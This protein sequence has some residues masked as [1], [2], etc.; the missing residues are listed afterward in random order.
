MPYHR[1]DILWN[2]I[3]DR[4]TKGE[5]ASAIAKDYPVSRQDI[6]KRVKKEG[7]Q[8]DGWLVSGKSFGNT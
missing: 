5:S 6:Q 8:Q 3:R 2:E 4:Y 1:G 7:W